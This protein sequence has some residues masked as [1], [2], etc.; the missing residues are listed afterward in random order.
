V[1]STPAEELAETFVELADAVAG[2]FDLDDFLDLFADRS[3]RLLDV[4]AV[5]LSLVDEAGRINAVGA[6]GTRARRLAQLEDGPG[7]AC[8]QAGA[9]VVVPELSLAAPRWP[10]FAA[11]A[12]AAGFASVHAVPMRRETQSLG[13]LQL[14]RTA[15]GELDK[16]TDRIAHALAD[17]AAI[18]LLQVRALREQL[19]LATQL[20]HAL[21]SRVLIEQ[22]KGVTGERLGMGM[23]DAFDILRRYARS[24]N[25]R[26]SDLAS[27]VVD[28]S[29]DTTLLRPD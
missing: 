20:Q 10:E 1:T 9:P 23:D 12:T 3:V 26:I 15:A 28:G 24:R 17:L 18:E 22:A 27:S 29:F 8:Y 11:T 4:S 14:F 2:E 6:S 21:T 7:P 16:S 19:G 25:L 5:G 13:A